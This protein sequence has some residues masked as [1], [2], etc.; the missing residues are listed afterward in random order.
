MTQAI[1]IIAFPVLIGLLLFLLPASLRIIKGIIASIAAIFS[2]YLAIV[3]FSGDNRIFTLGE[4]LLATGIQAP[5]M[6][7]YVD[8][9]KYCS[10]SIDNLSKLITL[11]ISML[12]L[13]IIIYSILYRTKD[14]MRNYYAYVLITLGFSFGAVLANNLLLFLICW[15]IL[16]LTLY[17]LIRG[18]DETSSAAAKKTLVI[19]GASD[20]I[21]ILGIAIIWRLTGTLNMNEISLHTG[22][23]VRV[24][25][26]L[27]LLVGSFTK[28]GAFPFHSWI[29]DYAEKAP[30]TSSAYL[31]ASLDKLLGIYFLARIT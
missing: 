13:L 9:V 19:I 31:P 16:G 7:A 6:N 8:A 11:F 30:A 21:M 22:D 15:G 25:A 28:A 26:F 27:A 18:H 5:G 14:S 24:I 1:N 23:A 4:W 3:I 17:K 29:P 2:T 20:G 12:S 10:F